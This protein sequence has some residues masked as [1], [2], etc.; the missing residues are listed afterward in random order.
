MW[1]DDPT[2]LSS[3]GRGPLVLGAVGG[4]MA[5]A[6]PALHGSAPFRGQGLA[7]VLN[8]PYIHLP[9]LVG[10]V[11]ALVG[12]LVQREKTLALSFKSA[13]KIKALSPGPPLARA[14][15]LGRVLRCILLWDSQA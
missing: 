15:T 10:R 13:Q 9:E 4:N 7:Q 12:L 11:S 8:F 6:S 2:P 14:S 1:G 3:K 5:E